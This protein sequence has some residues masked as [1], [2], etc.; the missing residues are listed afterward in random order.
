[1]AKIIMTG[2]KKQIRR[3]NRNSEKVKVDGWVTI[4]YASSFVYYCNNDKGLLHLLSWGPCF[5]I[6]HIRA[7]RERHLTIYGC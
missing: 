4:S 7:G 5:P 2:T 6:G 1:M 3:C